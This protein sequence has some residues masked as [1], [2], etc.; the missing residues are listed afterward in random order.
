MQLYVE[1]A[2]TRVAEAINVNTG[3]GPH[4]SYPNMERVNQM[5]GHSALQER[6]PCNEHETSNVFAP[7]LV[8]LYTR[9]FVYYGLIYTGS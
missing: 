8:H 4:A 2:Y 1:E 6:M 7:V 3:V 9:M 5:A